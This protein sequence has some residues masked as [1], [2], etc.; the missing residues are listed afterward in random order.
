ML[1]LTTLQEAEE[2]PW[3]PLDPSSDVT[4]LR[5]QHALRAAQSSSDPDPDLDRDHRA[6][7]LPLKTLRTGV[8]NVA[9]YAEE[10]VSNKRPIAPLPARPSS[11]S[12]TTR[13]KGKAPAPPLTPAV[14]QRHAG[15]NEEQDRLRR[16]ERKRRRKERKARQAAAAAGGGAGK[17]A[18]REA[19][20]DIDEHSRD[21]PGELYG[22]AGQGGKK[23]GGV[24]AAM[25][26]R[27]GGGVQNG[28][29]IGDDDDDDRDER[30][31]VS[32]ADSDDDDSDSTGDSSLGSAAG[33]SGASDN[34][35]N[36]VAGIGFGGP[37][38]PPTARGW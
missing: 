2:G 14:S 29:D 35:M 8:I 38:K 11:R 26:I 9:F 16:K 15:L 10:H 13:G 1:N 4:D 37:A 18:W 6:Y 23:K 32:S 24:G 31:T 33:L 20:R 30:N 34:E 3:V 36:S 19:E 22:G 7:T 27:M 21:A 28:A 25:G 12:Q 5:R 17:A